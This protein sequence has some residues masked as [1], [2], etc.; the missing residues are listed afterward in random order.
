MRLFVAIDLSEEARDHIAAEQ[1]RIAAAVAHDDAAL[2]WVRPAHMHLT[3]VFIGEMSEPRAAT[4]VE[5]ASRPIP[6]APFDVSFGGL[7]VFPERG[8]PRVLWLGVEQGAARVAAV[9]RIVAAALGAVGVAPEARAFHP[10]LTLARWRGGRSAYSAGIRRT[11][12]A[13]HGGVIARVTVDAVVLYQSRLSSAG[14]TYTPLARAPLAG[15]P[16]APVQ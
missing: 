12:G 5:A 10:H 2:R 11:I 16:R 6:A 15:A 14:P 4:I 8:G 13:D 1:K 9:Q 7:G 3:L